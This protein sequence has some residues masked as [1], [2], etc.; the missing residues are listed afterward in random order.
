VINE[1]LDVIRGFLDEQ[2][3]RFANG[4]MDALAHR[5]RP[6]EFGG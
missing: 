3:A 1:Y 5:V 2:A 4:V 6:A